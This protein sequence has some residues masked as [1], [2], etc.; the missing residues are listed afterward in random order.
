MRALFFICMERSLNLRDLSGVDACVVHEA[1]QCFE[2]GRRTDPGHAVQ[3]SRQL[4]AGRRYSDRELETKRNK[5]TI[6]F[7]LYCFIAFS[8]KRSH[9]FRYYNILSI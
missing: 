7:I 6:Y 9:Y 1:S 3:S 4:A 8:W 2:R 5:V